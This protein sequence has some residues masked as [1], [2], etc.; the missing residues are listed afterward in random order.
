MR[1]RFISS[2]LIFLVGGLAG[3]LLRWITWPPASGRAGETFVYDLV[4]LLWPTQ[5]LAVAEASMGKSSAILLAI[6]ANLLLFGIAGA[7]VI[8]ASR[9]Q[10]IAG[11]VA[12][13]F[14]GVGVVLLALWGAGFDLRF[15]NFL[16]LFVALGFYGLLVYLTRIFPR[17]RAKS[18]D[19]Q[20][21]AS[22]PKT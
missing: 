17:Q 3:P 18:V 2:V 16:A 15:M 11:I 19:K 13:G 1:N 9:L 14:P 5:M 4:F 8:A 7:L 10:S 22:R 21:L 6:G 20:K 12:Y